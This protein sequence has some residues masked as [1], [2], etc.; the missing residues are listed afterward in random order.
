MTAGRAKVELL[1]FFTRLVKHH[2][3]IQGRRDDRARALRRDGGEG[4]HRRICGDVGRV[5]GR[6][7][8]V[9]GG[10]Q[11]RVDGWDGAACIDTRGERVRQGRCCFS[12]CRSA[13]RT[14]LAQFAK[15]RW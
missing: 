8:G 13:K 15:A 12:A 9:C 1:G 11:H 14:P 7:A 3:N 6:G 2:P 10:A 5:H 4:C